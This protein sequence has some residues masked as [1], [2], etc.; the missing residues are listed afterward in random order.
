MESTEPGAW[1]PAFAKLM[2]V[3]L[4]ADTAQGPC[5]GL[6]IPLI[7]YHKAPDFGESLFPPTRAL[8]IIPKLY[9]ASS[10][11]YF[12]IINSTG[13]VFW[14]QKDPRNLAW[15]T[16]AHQ[17]TALNRRRLDFSINQPNS[18]GSHPYWC[19]LCLHRSQ[20]QGVQNAGGGQTPQ[21]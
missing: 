17:F 3:H 13:E 21:H 12:L 6:P 7:P 4:I 20:E 10:L 11:L 5:R 16:K 2:V 18:R 8:S 19:P 1:N 14:D 9:S 15:R